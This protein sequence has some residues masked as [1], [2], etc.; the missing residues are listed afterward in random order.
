VAHHGDVAEE[1]LCPC[2]VGIASVRVSEVV[3]GLDRLVRAR[4]QE[5]KDALDVSGRPRPEALGCM[6]VAQRRPDPGL[7][8]AKV[9]LSNGVLVLRVGGRLGVQQD[10]L[11]CHGLH[12]GSVKARLVVGVPAG[13]APVAQAMLDPALNSTENSSPPSPSMEECA[14]SAWPARRQSDVVTV[15]R[16]SEYPASVSSTSVREGEPPRT[17]GGGATGARSASASREKAWSLATFKVCRR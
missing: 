5:V 12:L 16:V 13:D 17:K 4:G 9:P 3:G 2:E 15:P 6:G 7:E 10:Q 1:R 11:G 8:R 14:S